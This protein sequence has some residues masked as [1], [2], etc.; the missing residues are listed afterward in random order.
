M[1]VKEKKKVWGRSVFPL[2]L[3]SLSNFEIFFAFIILEILKGHKNLGETV[4]DGDD[5]GLVACTIYGKMSA[6]LRARKM[7]APLGR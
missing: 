7:S 1:V 2:L 3:T 5:R 6:L 4:G